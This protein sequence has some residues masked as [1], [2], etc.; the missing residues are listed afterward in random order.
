MCEKWKSLLWSQGAAVTPGKVGE[1]E[2]VAEFCVV[3]KMEWWVAV[4]S[5]KAPRI[6]NWVVKYHHL[7]S[8]LE[9]F[10]YDCLHQP[11]GNS[12]NSL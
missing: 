11:P 2:V 1:C 9:I 10:A 7:D 5:K 4:T 8:R 6:G 3:C 12:I